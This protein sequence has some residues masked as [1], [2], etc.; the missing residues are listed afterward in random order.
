MRSGHFNILSVIA[1]FVFSFATSSCNQDVF[2]SGGDLPAHTEVTVEGDGGQWSVPFSRNG[3]T[4]IY[5][6]DCPENEKQYLTYL[7]VKGDLTGSYCDASDLKSINFENPARWYSFEFEGDMLYFSSNYNASTPYTV[8]LHLDYNFGVTKLI[9]INLTEGKPL[10]LDYYSP[11]GK[12]EI[13]EDIEI[14]RSTRLV[15][16]SHLTQKLEIMPFSEAFCMD[17]ITAEEAWADGLVSRLPMLIFDGHQWIWEEYDDIRIGE[18]RN[19]TP[20]KFSDQKIIVNVTPYKTARVTYTLHYTRN[21]TDGE[22]SFYN[23]VV[24]YSFRTNVTWTAVYATSFDYKVD[25]E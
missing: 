1:V 18:W 21:R 15:N 4:H 16:N 13:E 6:V 25:Y 7:N 5:I 19:F 20:D 17:E 9:S 12:T 8:N 2:V 11:F 23:S 14:T 24:D 10:R 22:I 3:L